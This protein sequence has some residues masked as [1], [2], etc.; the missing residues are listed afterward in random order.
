[1]RRAALTLA[2]AVLAGATPASAELV[3]ERGV[4]VAVDGDLSP[5]RLPRH[6]VAPV[7]VEIGGR[8]SSSGRGGPPQLEQVVFAFNSAGRLSTRGLPRCRLGH[9]D[10]S[11]TAEALAACREALVGQGRFSA[12]VRFPEQ[13]PF[14]SRGKVLAFNGVLRGRPTILAHIYGTVPV[15]TSY[16]LPLEI[17]RGGGTFGTRLIASLPRATGEWGHVTGLRLALGRT[18][19][20]HDKPRSF[21][22]AGCPAPAGFPGALF[23]LVRTSFTFEGTGTLTTTLM[24][25]CRTIE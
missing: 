4:R 22:A 25:S 14:P 8:I 19:S 16:V 7:E 2:F 11:T 13:S 1:L 5:S 21:L 12:N 23:P 18:F 10:P 15:P 24:R 20:V 17:R 3:Q 6:G 9:I